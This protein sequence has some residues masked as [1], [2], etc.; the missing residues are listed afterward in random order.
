MNTHHFMV[1][2]LYI[3]S[4]S[5]STS[6]ENVA[7]MLYSKILS[8]RKY[9]KSVQKNLVNQN[10]LSESVSNPQNTQSD[11]LLHKDISDGQ[12][13]QF[14]PSDIFQKKASIQSDITE[15]C[16]NISPSRLPD[17]YCLSSDDDQAS[18]SHSNTVLKSHPQERNPPLPYS[19]GHFDLP[20]N[21]E[22][23]IVPSHSNCEDVSAPQREHI[24]YSC[25]TQSSGTVSVS[26]SIDG[27]TSTITQN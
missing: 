14:L 21:N 1:L 23:D 15:D 19:V 20:P 8:V 27:Q 7:D 12:S 26:G 5:T 16:L 6:E 18:C 2:K 22:P 3:L 17:I 9:F 11:S 24:I 10:T 13:S 4:V 25:H